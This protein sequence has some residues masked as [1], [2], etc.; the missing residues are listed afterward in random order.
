[1]LRRRA[2]AWRVINHPRYQ[3]GCVLWWLK[4]VTYTLSPVPYHHPDR[5][6]NLPMGDLD[7]CRTG[8]GWG[9]CLMRDAAVS[10]MYDGAPLPPGGGGACAEGWGRI[11][12]GV[13]P[14]FRLW[15]NKKPVIIMDSFQFLNF[16]EFSNRVKFLFE[17][18]FQF[19]Q[20]GR[21][22]K[23]KYCNSNRIIWIENDKNSHF[24]GNIGNLKFENL[25]KI[26]QF[27]F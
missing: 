6:I 16:N 13:R 5:V 9:F 11:C 24:H 15:E 20:L 18:F 3:Y 2:H 14:P 23:F 21:I 8:A 7:R 22:L 4:Q 10:C 12:D 27:K 1:M 19:F 25:I 17:H 26:V